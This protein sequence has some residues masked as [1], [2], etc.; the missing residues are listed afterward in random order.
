MKSIFIFLT[1]LLSVNACNENSSSNTDGGSTTETP[2]GTI[3]FGDTI[4]LYYQES[5]QFDA[6]TSVSFTELKDSRC[7]KD[8]N[9][10]QAGQ[11]IA[12]VKVEQKDAEPK[13]VEMTSKGM[14]YRDD[15]GCGTLKRIGGYKVKLFNIYPYPKN[16]VA[17]DLKKSYLKIMINK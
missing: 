15:E 4:K 3:S 17:K 9:C 16:G 10:I 1:I 5:I 7:P 11:A 13:I 2:D 14:C 8:V 12:K 6:S